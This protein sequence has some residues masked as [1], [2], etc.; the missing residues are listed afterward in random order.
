[1][2]G[3]ARHA[4]IF[5]FSAHNGNVRLAAHARWMTSLVNGQLS[6]SSA[7]FGFGRISRKQHFRL[8][9]CRGRFGLHHGCGTG[10]L[11]AA[12]SDSLS[13]IER[14]SS[15]HA[16]DMTSAAFQKS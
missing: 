2:N 3:A 14:F 8:L 11:I 4:F 10:V 5:F 6:V 7:L 1:L 16:T 15:M 9:K 13:V 12:S